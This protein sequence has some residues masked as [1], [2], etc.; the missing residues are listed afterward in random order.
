VS[1]TYPAPTTCAKCGRVSVV[2]EGKVVKA[3]DKAKT[4]W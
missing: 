4:T 1:F 2:R 3:Y